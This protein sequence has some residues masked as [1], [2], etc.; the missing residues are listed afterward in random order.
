MFLTLEFIQSDQSYS[1]SLGVIRKTIYPHTSQQSGVIER[2]HKHILDVTYTIMLQM[3]VPKYLWYDVVLTAFF[4]I[5]RMPSTPFGG[6]IP[7]R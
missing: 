2:T 4:L 3:K 1:A 7:F 5:N 6:E